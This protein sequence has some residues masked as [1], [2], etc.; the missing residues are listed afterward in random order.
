MKSSNV[1]MEDEFKKAL[2]EKSEETT[3]PSAIDRN[4]DILRFFEQNMREKKM[5]ETNKSKVQ[6]RSGISSNVK[7]MKYTPIFNSE[8]NPKD[9]HALLS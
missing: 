8:R 7:E 9:K 5:I 1:F 3:T 2:D 4:A 6:V